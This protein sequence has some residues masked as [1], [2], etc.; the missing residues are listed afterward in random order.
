M[1]YYNAE[2][3]NCD[4][5][6][7]DARELLVQTQTTTVQDLTSDTTM[8]LTADRT[9]VEVTKLRATLKAQAKNIQFSCSFAFDSI[10]VNTSVDCVSTLGFCHTGTLTL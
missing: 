3:F 7:S 2:H 6:S 5:L 9:G 4:L 1:L 10:C 8:Q